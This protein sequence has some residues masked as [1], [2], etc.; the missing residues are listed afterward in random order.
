[1]YRAIIMLSQIQEVDMIETGK[2]KHC[3]DELL[4][5]ITS[6]ATLI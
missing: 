5:L 3:L 2:G 4:S 1:M 6:A